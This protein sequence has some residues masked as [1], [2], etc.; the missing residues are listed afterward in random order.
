MCVRTEAGVSRRCPPLTRVIWPLGK[1]EGGLHALHV[2]VP[3]Q[4]PVAVQA[5]VTGL[6]VKPG[7]QRQT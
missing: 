7:E 3:D 5:R 2:I 4:P 6:P 1:L